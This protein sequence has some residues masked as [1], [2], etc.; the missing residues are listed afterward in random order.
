MQWRL[1]L[2]KRDS[3][4]THLLSK[5]FSFDQ[6]EECRRGRRKGREEGGNEREEKVH[7]PD[8]MK[9]ISFKYLY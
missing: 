8:F 5:F 6:R 4:H 9:R 7:W 2:L 3:P 1:V